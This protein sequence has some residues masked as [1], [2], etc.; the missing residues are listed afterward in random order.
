MRLLILNA[1]SSSLKFTVI[2]PA[3]EQV[4]TRGTLEMARD[5]QGI[6]TASAGADAAVRCVLEAARGSIDAVAHRVVHGGARFTDPVRLTPEVRAALSA[7]T[8]I[9]PLHNPPSLTVIDAAMRT[10]PDVAHVAVF[11]TAFHVTLPPEAYTYPIPYGWS[12]RWGLR[13]FGFHGLSHAYAA[14]RTAEILERSPDG[15]NIVVA[16]LGNGASVTAIESGR[17]VDTTMGFTP[18]EGLMMGTRSGSVDP[19]LLVYLQRACGLTVGELDE[20]L[21]TESG[22]LGV[23][24]VSSDMR[25]VLLAVAT[26]DAR[27]DLAVR[28]FV[29]RARQAIGAMAVTLGRVDALVFTGGIGEHSPEVRAAICETL[30]CLGLRIDE[31]ANR[32]ETSDSIISTADSTGEILLITAREDLMMART[33]TASLPPSLDVR[34]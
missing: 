12:T 6:P 4:S 30:S 16:H 3:T 13:R 15:L 10:W 34:P 14:R 28:L 19:G 27:A 17:S 22:L 2:D 23:S 7:L 21:H 11:D 1:G 32:R 18:L 29:H 5:T 26:G 9:A 24:G 20:G 25:K 33:V 8:P 31:A